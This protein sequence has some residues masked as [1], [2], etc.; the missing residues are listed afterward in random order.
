MQAHPAPFTKWGICFTTFHPDSDRGHCYII[1]T[2]NYFT[3]WVEAMLTFSND[4][5]TI[6]LFIFN[7]IVAR[8]GISKDN[9]T[10][11]GSYFHNKMMIELK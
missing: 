1:M 7:Q 6:A 4:G 3:K 9:V 5:E 11:H 8:F 2:V 10:D